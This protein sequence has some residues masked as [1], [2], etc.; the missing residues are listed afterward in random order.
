MK[1][2]IYIG[3]ISALLLTACGSEE[4]TATITPDE[5]KKLENG[6]SPDEV[7]EIVGGEAKVEEENQFNDLLVTLRFEGENG[8]EK[9]SS[10]ELLFNDGK[11]DVIMEDGLITKRK[12]LT[13]E[14][15]ERIAENTANLM[16][17]SSTGAVDEYV[18]TLKQIINNIK[19]NSIINMKDKE[20]IEANRYSIE[21]TSDIIVFIDVNKEDSIEVIR[22]AVT[23]N[24]LATQNKEVEIAFKGLLQSVDKTLSVPQQSAILEELGF[25]NNGKLVD[26]TKAY[27]LNNVTYTYHSSIE[28]DSVILQAKLK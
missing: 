3:A 9:E 20:L 4:K 22:V 27:T 23:S 2:L 1:K 17:K 11:L 8:V 14:E 19:G 25:K 28:N 12:E 7:K 16:Y 21:L 18:S 6:M 10:A 13:K 5:F 15:K 24:A 26:H